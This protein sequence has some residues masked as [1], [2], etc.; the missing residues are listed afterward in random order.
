M[1]LNHTL[2]LVAAS[3]ALSSSFAVHAQTDSNPDLRLTSPAMAKMA[4]K[5]TMMS[6]SDAMK[7]VGDKAGAMAHDEKAAMDEA[8]KHFKQVYGHSR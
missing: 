4:D 7:S 1:K 6:K 8:Q 2:A 3:F 5:D